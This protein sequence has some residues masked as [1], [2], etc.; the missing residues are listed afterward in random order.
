MLKTSH[1]LIMLAL[2]CDAA[3]APAAQVSIGIGLPHASI[4]INLPA[5]PELMVVPGYPVYYAPQLD[6][7][8]FFYDGL[9][10]LFQDDEWYESSWYDGPWELV[11]PDDVPIPVLRVPVR[12]YRRPPVYFR[13]WQGDAPPHWGEHWGSHWMRHRRAWERWRGGAAPAPLPEYQRRYSGD[14][15]PRNR[16]QQRLLNRQNYRYQPSDRATQRSHAA[17]PRPRSAAPEQGEMRTAP[18]ELNREPRD[19]RAFSPP[20]APPVAPH[21]QAPHRVERTMPGPAMPPGPQHQGAPGAERGHP[22]AREAGPREHRPPASVNPGQARQ[23]K[24]DRREG[25]DRHGQDQTPG[26][27]QERDHGRNN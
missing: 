10:W 27:D 21:P 16:E 13:A 15:Y 14:R 5:Y 11:D 26:H 6:A 3:A 24:Q 23:G 12:Y 4:G 2:L 18:R 1:A 9:Y 7:N 19:R 8:Y 22:P 20:P 17:P 25:K